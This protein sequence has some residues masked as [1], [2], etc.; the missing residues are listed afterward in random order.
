[1]IK[2]ERFIVVGGGQ[3]ESKF[4]ELVKELDIKDYLEIRK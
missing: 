4:N 3:E 2:N 1:M